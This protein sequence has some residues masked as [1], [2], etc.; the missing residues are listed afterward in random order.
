M[1]ALDKNCYAIEL[2]GITKRFGPV[3]ANER[4]DLDIYR[5]EILALLGEKGSGKTKK[6]LDMAVQSVKTATG[7]IVVVD[8]DT[9]YMFDLPHEIRFVNASEYGVNTP[10]MCLG[11]LSG[12]LTQNFDISIVF[13]S[14]FSPTSL[15]E[16]I[17]AINRI[18]RERSCFQFCIFLIQF[19]QNNFNGSIIHTIFP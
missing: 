6:I 14:M 2:K 3:V 18:S 11:F 16:D 1:T 13:G 7:D 12:M 19:G 17:T 4:V 9:R 15:V 5:G 10:D 8:D